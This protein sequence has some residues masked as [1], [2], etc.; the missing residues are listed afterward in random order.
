MDQENY[1]HTDTHIWEYYSV[2][3]RK[4]VLSFVTT[5]MNLEAS[6]L[7]HNKPDR[8]RQ[9]LHGIPYEWN[10]KKLNC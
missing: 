4:K 1:V 2:L 6:T 3:K 10:I 5:Q 7:K 8:G 9:I